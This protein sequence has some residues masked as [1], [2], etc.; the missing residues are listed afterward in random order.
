MTCTDGFGF[1]GRDA[2]LQRILRAAAIMHP[3]PTAESSDK[4][5]A[6]VNVNGNQSESAGL[7]KGARLGAQQSPRGLLGGSNPPV[8]NSF[9]SLEGAIVFAGT[10]LACGL[11]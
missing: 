3:M 2:D 4:N 5:V 6:D 7:R 10:Q 8:P 1:D 9:A 11:L